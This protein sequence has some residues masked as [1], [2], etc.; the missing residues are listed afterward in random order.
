M[1]FITHSVNSRKG[2]TLVELLVVIAIIGILASIVLVSLNSA[3]KKARDAERL[4]HMR[5]I[6]SALEVYFLEHERF[7]TSDYDGCG[8]WD[9]GNDDHLFISNLGV[10]VPEYKGVMGNCSGYRYYRY[11]AGAYGCPRSC[12]AFYVLGVTFMESTSR[13]HPNSPGWSCSNR[14][15]QREMDWVTGKF[16]RC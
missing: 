6:Q 2:F 15:W 8:G 12:G 5:S 11:G 3:R 16:E 9:V 1:G 14:D 7:P 4:A 10:D 13:P